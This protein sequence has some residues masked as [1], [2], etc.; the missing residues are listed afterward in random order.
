MGYHIALNSEDDV[1]PANF[2][3]EKFTPSEAA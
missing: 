1:R 3:Y 2:R